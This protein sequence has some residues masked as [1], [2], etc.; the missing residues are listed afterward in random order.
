MK[1]AL[2]G[3]V[4]REYGRKDHGTEDH[5][6][7]VKAALDRINGQVREFIEKHK[8]SADALRERLQD[9][10]QRIADGSGWS[11]R[12]A[13]RSIDLKAITENDSFQRLQ[14]KAV[15]KT[16]HI[17]LDC[18]IKALLNYEGSPD[19]ANGTMPPNP[20]RI[21]GFHGYAL[22]PL[23]LLDLLPAVQQSTN[24]F[25]YT[26]LN[27]TGGAEV[28][29]GEGAEKAEMDFDGE[30]IQDRVATIAV[31]TTASAQVL[32]DVDQLQATL[33]D[34]LTHKALSKAEQ[35]LTIGSGVAPNIEGLYTASTAIT[36]YFNE[37]PDRIGEAITAME[38][39]GYSVNVIL[40]NPKDWLAISV[41][42][43]G[44][45]RYLYGN[46]ASP[47]APS[48]W[49][50]PVVTIPDLPL[51]TALVGDTSKT[52]VRDRMQPTVFIS[53]DH[54][55]YRT[56]NLV[57]ILVELRLGLAVFDGLAFRRVDLGPS[58]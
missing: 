20:E 21:P 34:I 58:T 29:D 43:D 28:Q 32:D 35:Q 7:E 14:E 8:G 19:T 1:T 40:M 52:Q 6:R 26:R 54:K 51:G 39:A 47:A 27:F 46:P 33:G 38:T 30:L 17:R 5:D 45:G 53:R 16:D 41:L 50:R 2:A 9:V 10:E 24:T 37:I 25:E 22:R 23:R 56:R 11:M 55:D 4:E 36:T 13:A 44:E 18:S 15:D 48:L 49:N 3:A 12:G 31:H 57:L 42:K